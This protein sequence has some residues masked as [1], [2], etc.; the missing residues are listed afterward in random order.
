MFDKTMTRG[1][2]AAV[3]ILLAGCAGH[4]VAS[5]IYSL[6]DGSR[7]MNLGYGNGNGSFVFA[8]E[9]SVQ[10]GGAVI[11][12]I[13]VS[14]GFET[15]TGT[16]VHVVLF[17]DQSD[18]ATPSHPVLL[19][20]ASG[21]ATYTSSN[22]TA[23]YSVPIPP[24]QVTGNFFIGVLVDARSSSGLY[25]INF[26]TTTPEDRSYGAWFDTQ[27]GTSALS[28]M[29]YDPNGN[30][31]V[32]LE[33]NSYNFVPVP[34]GNFMI[35]AVGQPVPEPATLTF[36]GTALLGLGVAYLRRRWA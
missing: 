8:N 15:V 29:T 7:N 17:Q 23:F 28:S 20:S 32:S 3:A 27:I 25:P 33:T 18:A 26:D 16:P 12:E 21:T 6:D 13:D 9:F 35:R 30:T 36:L 5:V 34:N 4:A 24:T 22:T 14:Y 11:S 2:L 10:P 31:T 19:A 1:L